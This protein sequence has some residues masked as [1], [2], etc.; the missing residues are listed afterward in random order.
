MENGGQE[1]ISYVEINIEL[2][3]S[4][5]EVLNDKDTTERKE[6]LS[7]VSDKFDF[8]ETVQNKTQSKRI[9]NMVNGPR[10]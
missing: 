4:G 5:Y 9:P 6:D 2:S 8:L 7:T 10:N 1:V 3:N